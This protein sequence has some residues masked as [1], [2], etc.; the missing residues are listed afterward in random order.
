[1]LASKKMVKC[2]PYID[3]LDEVCESCV[4]NKHHGASFAKKVNWKAKEPLELVHTNLCGPIKPMTTKHNR[5]F[6]T[7]IDD[8]S[9]KIS[10][11]ESRVHDRQRRSGVERIPH[12]C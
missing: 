5:Y 3:N 7:F 4:I 2:M 10:R 12:F 11:S 9:R 8:Y 1:M 6:L